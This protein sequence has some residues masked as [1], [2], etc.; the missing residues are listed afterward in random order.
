MKKL[1]ISQEST[2]DEEE[3]MVRSRKLKGREIAQDES[4]RYPE[5][6]AVKRAAAYHAG[7]FHAPPGLQMW[8]NPNIIGV[9]YSL[10][11]LGGGEGLFAPCLCFDPLIGQKLFFINFELKL[12]GICHD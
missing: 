3:P 1:A 4:K 12:E 10:I 2:E 7:G 6:T 11:V 5:D 9:K 8:I